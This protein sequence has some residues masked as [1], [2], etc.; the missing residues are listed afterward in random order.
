MVGESRTVNF[1]VSA[2]C[3]ALARKPAVAGMSSCS[4]RTCWMRGVVLPVL[5]RPLLTVVLSRRSRSSVRGEL[6]AP[7]K[8]D[9]CRAAAE[10]EDAQNRNAKEGEGEESKASNEAAA[11]TVGLMGA[12]S[13]FSAPPHLVRSVQCRER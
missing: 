2:Q 3:K 4:H 11:L 1:F 6:P 5:A 8:L 9:R 13:R 7:R 12:C 10:T